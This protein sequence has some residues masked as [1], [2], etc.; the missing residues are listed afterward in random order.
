MNLDLDYYLDPCNYIWIG[1]EYA[2][3]D[4]SDPN[5]IHML[6]KLNWCFTYN[7]LICLGR[8]LSIYFNGAVL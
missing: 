4:G 3:P 8:L 5:Q 6:P 7:K 1:A 2:G